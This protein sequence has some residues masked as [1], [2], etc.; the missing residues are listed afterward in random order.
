MSDHLNPAMKHFCPGLFCDVEKMLWLVCCGISIHQIS[1]QVSTTFCSCHRLV[2]FT[3]I[4]VRK[5]FLYKL[6]LDILMISTFINKLV[7]K[8]DVLIYYFS[9]Y[10]Q[11]IPNV[12]AG[13]FPL[14]EAHLCLMTEE[15][16]AVLAAVSYC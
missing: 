8:T 5:R 1:I 6:H 15:S 10:S 2:C 7:I 16:A 13:V 4:C 3:T 11:V 12:L 14:R 9:F